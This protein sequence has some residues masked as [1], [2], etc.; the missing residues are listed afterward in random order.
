MRY[1]K[2]YEEWD[3]VA[4]TLFNLVNCHTQKQIPYV[5]FHKFDSVLKNPD[6]LTKD[7]IG[8]LKS[9]FTK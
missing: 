5:K 9:M 1:G 8:R 4:M 7:N 2:E 3:R 6:R